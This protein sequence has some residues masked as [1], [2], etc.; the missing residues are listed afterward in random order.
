MIAVLRMDSS[1]QQP[2]RL[3][4]EQAKLVAAKIYSF[5]SAPET[6]GLQLDF[7]AL[8]TERTFYAELIREV[9]RL[10]PED[11]MLSIT[12]LASW[13]LFDNWM[14]SL[15]VDETG[16][17]MF[18]LGNERRKV[19]L[20]FKSGRQFIA[21]LCCRSLGISLEDTEVNQLMMPL[22]RNRKIPTRTYV[23]TRTAWNRA[24][25]QAVHSLLL[26]P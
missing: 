3:T 25:L 16:P 7:D 10:M 22:V 6:A 13:C 9:R 12:A 23:F 4:G 21:P 19:L 5:A 8:K 18:S 20:H 26:S 24:K 14:Q 17:M 11:K 1:R 2:P 15:P